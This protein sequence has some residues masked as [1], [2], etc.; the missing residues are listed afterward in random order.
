[1]RTLCSIDEPSILE[2]MCYNGA[3]F[4]NEN[5]ID[6]NCSR[7][8][9]ANTLESVDNSFGRWLNGQKLSTIITTGKP[10]ASQYLLELQSRG[11]KSWH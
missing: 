1:M 9:T 4:F 10:L 8:Y 2:L 6:M 5:H 11:M 7:I 3:A